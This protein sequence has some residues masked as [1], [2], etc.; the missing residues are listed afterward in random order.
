[1]TAGKCSYCD[2]KNAPRICINEL[3]TLVDT[4]FQA[5]YERTPN[6][7]DDDEYSILKIV[8]PDYEW[9]RDGDPV[10]ELISETVKCEEAIASE[11]L[12]TL[13]ARYKNHTPSNEHDD[14]CEFANESHY[15]PKKADSGDWDNMWRRLEHALKH[16]N[17]LFNKEAF[18]LLSLIF[19]GLDRSPSNSRNVAIITAGPGCNFRSLYRARE[20]QSIESLGDAL[21]SPAESLGA[22]P[23]R[24]AKAGRMNASG[25]AVFY[26]ALEAGSAL[27]EVRPV[28]G[29]NV[30]VA[31]FHI[32]R[33][34]QLLDLRSLESLS[35]DGSIFDPNYIVELARH[36]FLSTLS[37]R[38]TLPVMPSD[39]EHEYLITQAVA[40]YLASLQE[41]SLDGII[42][43]SVQDGSGVNVAL[44]HKA[45]MVEPLDFPPSTSIRVQLEDYNH[46][47]DESF[48]CYRLQID[49]Q[50][51]LKERRPTQ[52]FLHA[53][54]RQPTLKLD[55]ES[56][57]VHAIKA[58]EVKTEEDR[59]QVS[60]RKLSQADLF[61]F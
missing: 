27:A 22:P 58:V 14:E 55:L 42:F 3:A 40:D 50:E 35:C 9:E 53:K 56:L 30:V 17:R 13:G 12:I 43:P 18:D 29:S 34:L 48:P 7:P 59:V 47:I 46:A 4:A 61:P 15:K 5:H 10:S 32:M 54:N 36:R 1:M 41:P 38:L 2:E 8:F 45:S 57:T 52:H 31:K 19:A 51:D 25:I 39:Q 49:S 60:Y 33:D 21:N 23:G 24:L 16:E 44:F 20:F 28:V 11:L 26:G 37:K 6:T